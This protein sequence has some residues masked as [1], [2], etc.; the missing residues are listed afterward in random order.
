M[1]GGERRSVGGRALAPGEPRFVL[2]L[3]TTWFTD[4]NGSRALRVYNTWQDPTQDSDLSPWN[5][6]S[7]ARAG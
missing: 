2:Q 3:K 5:V 7:S 4:H 6:I 1:V